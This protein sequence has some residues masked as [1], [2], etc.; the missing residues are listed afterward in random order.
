MN[1]SG[2]KICSEKFAKLISTTLTVAMRL[3]HDDAGQDQADGPAEG[4]SDTR[5]DPGDAGC[6]RGVR[7]ILGR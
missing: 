1:D 2:Y 5:P 7:K 6:C 4:W 3:L